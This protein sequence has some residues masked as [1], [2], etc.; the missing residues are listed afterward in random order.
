MTRHTLAAVLLTVLGSLPCLPLAAAT[1]PWAQ[2]LT[3]Q[4]LGSGFLTRLPPTVSTAF[5][6][7]KAADGTDVRQLLTKDGH[8]IRTFNVSVASHSELVVFNVDAHS[9]ATTAYLLTPEGELRK[10]VSYRAGGEARPISPADAKAGFANEKRYWSARAKKAPA[11]AAAS[12]ATPPGA[13]S[14]P[15]APATPPKP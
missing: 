15:A 9:G 5:G 4:A 3:Q 1:I 10:A 8:R 6:L 12:P 7:P 2:A 14:P 13:A 11:T